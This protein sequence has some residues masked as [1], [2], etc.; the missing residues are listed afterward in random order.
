MDFSALDTLISK[1]RKGSP[2]IAAAFDEVKRLLGLLEAGSATVR[3]D[4]LAAVAALRQELVASDGAL[5][6]RIDELE[7]R[8]AALEDPVE[9]P[10][11]PPP[12]PPAG[13]PFAEA[14][15]RAGYRTLTAAD[16]FAALGGLGGTNIYLNLAPGADYLIDMQW[17][18]W[19]RALKVCVPNGT[20][21]HVKNV[22][23]DVTVPASVGPYNRSGLGFRPLALT[24]APGHCSVTGCLITGT[25]L[26]DGLTFGQTGATVRGGPFTFQQMRI[27]SRSSRDPDG[28]VSKPGDEPSSEHYDA[29]HMQGPG[30]PVQFGNCTIVQCS[31]TGTDAGKGL[32]LNAYLAKNE[33]Y[34]LTNVNLRDDGPGATGTGAAWLKDEKT[35][36]ITLDNVWALKAGSGWD[37]ANKLLFYNT[38]VKGGAK[39]DWTITGSAPN[40]V[41]TFPLD[42]GVTGEV[43]EGR[44]PDGEDFVTRADLAALGLVV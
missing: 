36:T 37:W 14:S 43:R 1:F 2:N 33:A 42:D 11:P 7:Q 30:S 24:D 18:K 41:A 26:A 20:R 15:L 16:V 23:I 27:E 10:P 8:I 12:P 35:A 34:F 44:S 22:Y 32:M 6:A 25:T 39:I 17:A 5:D 40:R 31:T 13:L 9:P 19:N 21:V 29:F 3:V 4:A 28:V 38:P